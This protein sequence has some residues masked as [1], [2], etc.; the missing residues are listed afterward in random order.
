MA[1]K[2]LLALGKWM[3]V[4]L[5]VDLSGSSQTSMWIAKTG[6]VCVTAHSRN[7]DSTHPREMQVKGLLQLRWLLCLSRVDCL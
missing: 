6:H 4:V 7:A 2:E 1:L 5:I 3:V